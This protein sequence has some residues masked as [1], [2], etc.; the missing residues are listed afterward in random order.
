MAALE[1][2][3]GSVFRDF[4]PAGQDY[5]QREVGFYIRSVEIDN[6]TGQWLLLKESNIRIPPYTINWRI[7]IQPAARTIEIDATTPRGF[8]ST[9]VGEPVRLVCRDYEIDPSQGISMIPHNPLVQ[10][11]HNF[12]Q[13]TTGGNGG[14]LIQSAANE[15]IKLYE[16]RFSYNEN[17]I[18]T[19]AA[20]IPAICQLTLIGAPGGEFWHLLINAEKPSDE[21]VFGPGLDL[22]MGQDVGYNMLSGNVVGVT[23]DIAAVYSLL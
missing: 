7:N 18:I 9:T 3:I 12:D 16:A 17:E 6:P 1:T 11:E 5:A 19:G 8:S 14:T 2:A 15:R 4:I 20:L 21:T 13:A 10:R 23:C 22:A